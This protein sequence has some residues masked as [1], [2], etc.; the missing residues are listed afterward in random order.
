MV[1]G[2]RGGNLEDVDVNEGV[3]DGID[4]GSGSVVDG[5]DGGE[6]GDG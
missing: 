4:V 5:C 6:D 3:G 2:G 1:V